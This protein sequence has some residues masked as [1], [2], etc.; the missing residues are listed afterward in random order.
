MTARRTAKKSRAKATAPT[1]AIE[2]SVEFSPNRRIEVTVGTCLAF[3]AAKISLSLAETV[4]DGVELGVAVDERYEFLVEK[5]GEKFGDLCDRIEQDD[6]EDAPED[7][8][9]ALEDPEDVPEDELTE[10]EIN[11]MSKAELVQLVKD[12]GIEEEVNT[13][14]KVATLR[15]A[16]ID[17]LFVEDDP[18]DAPEDPEDALEDAPEDP[19]D[20]PEDEL[21][22]DEINSMSKPELVQLVKDEGIEEEVNTKA[23]VTVLRQAIIDALFVEDGEEWSDDKWGDGEEG[24]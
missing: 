4:K 1:P 8:E 14:A 24:E 5:L 7:P 12:E 15:Q 19:E 13:K 6:P 9:D 22:E 10:D 11:S 2:K 23:K 3:G 20:A 17:A 18:E 21:T 16:I